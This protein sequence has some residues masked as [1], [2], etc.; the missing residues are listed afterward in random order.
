MTEESGGTVPTTVAESDTAEADSDTALL[1]RGFACVT[2]LVPIVEDTG[3]DFA[4]L[5]DTPT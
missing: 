4:G 5:L 3:V 1:R 2:A